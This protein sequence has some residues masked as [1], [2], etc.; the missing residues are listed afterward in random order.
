MEHVQSVVYIEVIDHVLWPT[1][2]NFGEIDS[3][4][5]QRSLK[6]IDVWMRPE[7]EGRHEICAVSSVDC[8]VYVTPSRCEKW[9]VPLRGRMGCPRASLLRWKALQ[10]Q[11]FECVADWHLERGHVMMEGTM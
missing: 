11:Q 6:P 8:L 3:L 9:V 1:S 7:E 2:L 4:H 5:R 10:F